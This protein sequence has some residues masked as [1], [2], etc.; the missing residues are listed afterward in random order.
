MGFPGPCQVVIAELIGK[1]LKDLDVVVY[2][3]SWFRKKNYLIS[4]NSKNIF[5]KL[6]NN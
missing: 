1:S 6:T 2:V 5:S 4:D 3:E